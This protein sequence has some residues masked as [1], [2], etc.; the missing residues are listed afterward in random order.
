MD[1]GRRRFIQRASVL[2]LSLGGLACWSGCGLPPSPGVAQKAASVPRIAYLGLGAQP[3][4]GSPSIGALRQ[5]LR[6]LGYIEGQTILT[7]WRYADDAD[8]L[9]DVAADLVRR[10]VHLIVVGGTPQAL[11]ARQAT[12][13]IPVVMAAA[14]D[15]V[16]AGLV[17]S[18]ARPG[19]NVTGLSFLSLG[20]WAKQLE[21]LKETVP[22]LSR[23]AVPWYG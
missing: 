10:N 18:L 7:E 5:G 8:Q 15:P 19:G 12:S 23:V 1:R 21:L 11:A 2:G 17:A 16:G 22:A 20:I 9:P 3:V 14:D 6:D 4:E 13:T